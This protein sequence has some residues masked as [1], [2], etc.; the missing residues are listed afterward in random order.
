MSTSLEKKTLASESGISQIVSRLDVAQN[1][2]IRGG[3]Y[4]EGLPEAT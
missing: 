3:K 4:D 1:Y 2:L